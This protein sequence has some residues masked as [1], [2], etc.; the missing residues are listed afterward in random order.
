MLRESRPVS[1]RHPLDVRASR[2]ANRVTDISVSRREMRSR[3]AGHSAAAPE[4]GTGWRPFRAGERPI[5]R[6]RVRQPGGESVAHLW[7]TE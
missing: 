6:L 2:A 4:L 5:A 3:R 7:G 1:G